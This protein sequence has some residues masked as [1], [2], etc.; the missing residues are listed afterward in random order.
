MALA[1]ARGRATARAVLRAKVEALAGA[2]RAEA[3]DGSEPRWS[4]GL[5]RPAGPPP[6]G[7]AVS[8]V[9]DVARWVVRWESALCSLWD[10]GAGT[11]RPTRMHVVQ[12][13]GPTGRMGA[14]AEV[15]A[16]GAPGF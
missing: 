1:L 12:P 5:D 3:A 7:R 13:T 15:S 10:A 16:R 11:A 9:F 14:P 2:G 4:L 8:A 6:S